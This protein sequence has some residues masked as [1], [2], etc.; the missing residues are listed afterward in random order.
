MIAIADSGAT[1]TDWV[2]LGKDH[3]TVHAQTI[4]FNPYFIDTEG[5]L[6]ELKKN[7]FPYLNNTLVNEV[8]FYGAGC[9]TPSNCDIVRNALDDFF[10]RADIHVA[11]DLL[12]AARALLGKEKGIAC[13]LGT[14][15][16]SCS[17]DGHVI[18]ANVN[19]MGYI[20][21]D[22]GSGAYMGKQL[23]RD[24]FLNELPA[25]LKRAFDNKYNYTLEHVLDAV[26]NKPHPNRFLA[27]FSLFLG[28]H[29]THK[30]IRKLIY[31]AFRAF[32]IHQVTKYDNYKEVP[33]RAVGSVAWHYK[34][35]LKEMAM[36]FGASIDKVLSRPLDGLIEYHTT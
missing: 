10:T 36:E 30:H 20:L 13:I 15:S 11:H 35:L 8:H 27:S 5:I 33:V 14:G 9:S 18:T 7:L 2:F 21:A 6:E 34:E 3:D 25:D 12:G 17:Y 28:E 24:Y 29:I 4:G 19:S 32:F 16:N 23:I 22:E 31:D 1:K 26:Y